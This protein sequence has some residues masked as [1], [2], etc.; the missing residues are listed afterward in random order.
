MTDSQLLAEVYLELSG[1]RQPNFELS[2][3]TYPIQTVSVNPGLHDRKIR[4]RQSELPPRITEK[5][6]VAHEAFIKDLGDEAL[7]NKVS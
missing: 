2:T 4:Q 6:K 1:G 7:W 5:E 3:Q